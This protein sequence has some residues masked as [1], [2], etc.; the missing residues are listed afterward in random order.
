MSFLFPEDQGNPGHHY[1]DSTA[2][3][4]M[5]HR[6]GN[7]KVRHLSCRVLWC[8]QQV[9]E[10][11]YEINNVEGRYNPAD[12]GTKLL[13]K[14]RTLQLLY[15]FK[16]YHVGNSEFVGSEE[17]AHMLQKTRSRRA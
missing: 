4:G 7:G 8:Q 13:T 10:K 1:L 15:M 2:A 17:Y 6:S 12:L 3:S 11:F 5:L 16:A 9:K 14:R